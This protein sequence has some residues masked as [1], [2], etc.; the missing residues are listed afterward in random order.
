MSKVKVKM[1]VNWKVAIVIRVNT[2]EC[3][4]SEQIGNKYSQSSFI[5]EKNQRRKPVASKVNLL[6]WGEYSGPKDDLAPG[7]HI[8]FEVSNDGTI[9]GWC[10]HEE[11]KKMGFK[12]LRSAVTIRANAA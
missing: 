3:V 10:S 8:V 9:I 6:D 1:R 12:S 11:Y 4:V 5:V 7:H 2:E